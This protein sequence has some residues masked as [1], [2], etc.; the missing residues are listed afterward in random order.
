M[1]DEDLDAIHEEW[2]KHD[3]DLD[4]PLVQDAFLVLYKALGHLPSLLS[5]AMTE[6]LVYIRERPASQD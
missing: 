1:S 6:A 4:D 2:L 5:Q 3:K